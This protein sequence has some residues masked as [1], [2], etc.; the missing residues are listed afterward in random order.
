MEVT[1]QVGFEIVNLLALL[2]AIMKFSDCMKKD[3]QEV[4]V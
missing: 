3:K 4:Q 2:F 1:F